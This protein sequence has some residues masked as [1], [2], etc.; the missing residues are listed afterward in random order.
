MDINLQN[1]FNDVEKKSKIACLKKE[2]EKLL[3]RLEDVSDLYY[4]TEEEKLILDNYFDKTNEAVI[5]A[6]LESMKDR[7]LNPKNCVRK[8]KDH[9]HVSALGVIFPDCPHSN[10][11]LNYL[12]DCYRNKIE[13]LEL[14]N[15][16]IIDLK[17]I[18]FHRIVNV[19]FYKI[20]YSMPNKV[21]IIVFGHIH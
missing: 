7:L 6:I 15:L 1:T 13:E 4:F 19:P 9:F 2:I 5:L 21:N 20:S 11:E 14:S 3:L 10:N 8:R 16:G 18:P 17:I 12:E